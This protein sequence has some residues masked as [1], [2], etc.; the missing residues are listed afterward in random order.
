MIAFITHI[1]YGHAEMYTLQQGTHWQKKYCSRACKNINN[2]QVLQSYEAQRARG[3]KSKLELI[4]IKGMQCE[5]CG[6]SRN[7]AA[8]EFHH[9]DPASKDFQ[10]DLRSLSNRRWD[11]ILAEV[12]KCLLLCSNCHAE[13]HNPDCAL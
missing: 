5:V 6:Y 4:R 13:L 12:K 1:K 10:L 3:R 2:N 9:T 7:Y 8:L 11:A